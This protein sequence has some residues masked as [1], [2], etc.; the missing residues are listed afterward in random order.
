MHDWSTSASEGG[1]LSEPNE[2]PLDPPLE[3][4]ICTNPLRD[5]IM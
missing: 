2:S 1:G 4:S 3:C 5:N